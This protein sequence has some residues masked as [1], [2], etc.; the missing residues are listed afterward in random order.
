MNRTIA[1]S[2]PKTTPRSTINRT[3]HRARS[4]IFSIIPWSARAFPPVD[5]LPDAPVFSFGFSIVAQDVGFN[6]I[7]FFLR[8]I[9]SARIK[10]EDLAFHILPDKKNENMHQG[11]GVY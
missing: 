5:E 3:F 1:E 8:V 7:T 4:K 11:S 10:V 6:E 9:L 2:A